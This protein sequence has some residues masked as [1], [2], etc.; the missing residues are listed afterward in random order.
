MS[1]RS[2]NYITTQGYARLRAELRHLMRVERPR[3][4]RAVAEAA[5]QG[6]RS[7]NADYIYGRRRLAEI[8]RRIRYLSRRLEHA[9]VVDPSVDR[10]DTVYFG[11]TVVLEEEDG[12]VRTVQIVGSDEID[13]SGRRASWSAPLGRAILG[14]SVGDAVVVRGP[15]G[16]REVVILEVRYEAVED[17]T[18]PG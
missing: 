16:E 18:A 5:E 4:V 15:K 7:E 8:D 10:G 17:E 14:R 1:D 12:S 11:A 13:G 6:D 3:V 9:V 2:P